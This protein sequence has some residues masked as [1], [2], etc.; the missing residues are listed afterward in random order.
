MILFFTLCF[1]VFYIHRRGIQ[2]STSVC[3]DVCAGEGRMHS[4][5][6]RER[7]S[8]CV[9][10]CACMCVCAHMCVCV[11]VCAFCVFAHMDEAVF[12][13]WQSARQ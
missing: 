3:R 10:G 8:V 6:E 7:E 12:Q 11:C 4:E 9:D 5:R 1:L 13:L 2:S